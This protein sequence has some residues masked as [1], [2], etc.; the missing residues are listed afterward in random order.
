MIL[1]EL[2]Q[3]PVYWPLS[4]SVIHTYTHYSF[5]LVIKQW[6][7]QLSTPLP[8]IVSSHCNLPALVWM[9]IYC[10][11]EC[12]FPASSS[13]LWEARCLCYMMQVG[14]QLL[15]SSLVQIHREVPR[16]FPG[17]PWPLTTLGGFDHVSRCTLA[18]V[19]VANLVI[20]MTFLLMH[21][22]II[23]NWH[24]GTRCCREQFKEENYAGVLLL[25]LSF[26]MWLH[27]FWS[28]SSIVLMG[29]CSRQLMTFWLG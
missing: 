25:T 15:S 24:V 16:N 23:S 7:Y 12:T 2:S 6:T 29:S 13:V 27:R 3:A 21:H 10:H 28:S 17:L 22:C 8:I 4:D 19:V 14:T 18:D 11:I 20:N 26:Y 1:S 5:V 9:Q